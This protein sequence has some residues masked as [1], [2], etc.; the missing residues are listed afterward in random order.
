MQISYYKWAPAWSQHS[1]PAS[2][3]LPVLF[4]CPSFGEALKLGAKK[5]S[6]STSAKEG[7]LH[8][9]HLVAWLCSTFT[10]CLPWALSVSQPAA[11][12]GSGAAYAPRPP[13]AP[14]V[15]WSLLRGG[16]GSLPGSLGAPLVW[17]WSTSRAEMTRWLQHPRARC[18]PGVAGRIPKPASEVIER[19][20]LARG[21][22]LGL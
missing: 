8:T 18:A 22:G 12:T 21:S 19:R 20:R 6:D 15:R 10:D 2:F 5:A 17:R 4:P 9:T 3:S 7:I 14:G 13:A 16:R 1:C 11:E